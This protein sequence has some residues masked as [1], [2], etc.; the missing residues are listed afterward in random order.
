MKKSLNKSD[1]K[2]LNDQI[3]NTFGL[4]V[5]FTK[6][7]SVSVVDDEYVFNGDLPSFFYKNGKLIPT[8][9]LLLIKQFLKQIVIDKGAVRFIANGADV[10]RP[11]IVSAD[12]AIQ[13]GELI[14]IVDP[15]HGKPL[16]VGEAL[17]S[18]LDIMNSAS[19]RSVKNIHYVGDDIWKLTEPKVAIIPK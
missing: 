14:A 2:S 7:D 15:V 9:R 5:C 17:A 6:K 8:L 1:I 19:G 18:G 11:G 10:M 12:S 13:A 3:Q 16:A 4:V